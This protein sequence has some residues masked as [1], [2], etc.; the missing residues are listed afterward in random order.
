MRCHNILIILL[1]FFYNLS[2]SNSAEINQEKTN[3]VKKSNKPITA[4]S[5]KVNSKKNKASKKNQNPVSQKIKAPD[6]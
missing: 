3:I 5:Q 6:F 1:L 2:C 4:V